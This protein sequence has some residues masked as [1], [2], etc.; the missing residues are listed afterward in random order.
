MQDFASIANY[1]AS[2]LPSESPIVYGM[3]PNA[4]LSLL[5]AEGETLFRTIFNVASGGGGGGAGGSSDRVRTELERYMETLPEPFIM[6]E[7]EARVVDKTPYVVVA[8]QV[9]AMRACNRAC[10]VAFAAPV[11]W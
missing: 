10:S 11:M 7:I 4:E 2:S 9:R 3:H 1:I 6:V 5:T 8:L